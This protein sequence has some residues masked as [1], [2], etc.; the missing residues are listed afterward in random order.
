MGG[1]I[2]TKRPT[3]PKD[4]RAISS[5]DFFL[6][7]KTTA[8]NETGFLTSMDAKAAKT[9]KDK[10]P[11]FNIERRAVTDLKPYA[12]NP[13]THSEE[14]IAQIAASIR[15]W[16]WT[17]PILIDPAGGVIAGHGRL[18]AANLLGIVEVPVIIADAWTDA[19]KRAYVMA[20]NQ[21]AINA[22]WDENLLAIEIGELG[23]GGFDIDL[24][25]FPELDLDS[26]YAP[27]LEPGTAVG[28]VTAGDVDKKKGDLES[29]FTDISKQTIIPIACPHCGEMFS[30]NK[31]TL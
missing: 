1:A 25:G 3:R 20:D 26:I 10:W 12:N 29:N 2:G 14:Q 28:L 24:L 23:V 8:F 18:Q 31:D 21:L 4:P 9:G 22:G 5:A 7:G 17:S 27:N 11:A 13:R 15:E 16:G 19:Q 30:V 6:A